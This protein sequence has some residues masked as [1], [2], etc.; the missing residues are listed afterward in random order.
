MK[1][2]VTAEPFHP[3]EYIK[4]ELEARGWTQ[5]D[6]AQV[7]DLSRRQIVNLISGK[8]G[9]S[10]DVARGLAK[11]FD[12]DAETWMRLQIV[13]E[14]SLS[15]Q[16]DAEKQKEIGRRAALY[17]KAPVADMKRRGW[18]PKLKD[19]GDLERAVCDFLGIETI[20][21]TPSIDVAARK[22]TEYTHDTVAQIAWYCRAKQMAEQVSASRYEE[23]N[24]GAMIDALRPL[25]AYP[26][27]VRR[28]PRIL[29]DWGVRLVI[30]E[31]LPKT[32]VDG[33]ALW[34]GQ[35]PAIALS[36]RH[37]QQD[38]FWFTLFHE[39]MH[40]KH[41]HASAVDTDLTE[42]DDS[43]LPETERIVNAEASE[44]MIPKEK[45]DSFIARHKPLFYRTKIIQ[46]AQARGVHPGIVV[47]Q[48]QHRKV[49]PMTHLQRLF[50]QIRPLI[51]GQAR[52]DG[53]D[54]M[55]RVAKQDG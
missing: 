54:K 6:L 4:D 18:I 9:V 45:L 19:V 14:L 29:A 41:K 7:M 52:T 43:G 31:H 21:Q 36:L 49:L 22:S 20:D 13:Y 38:R 47:G 27:E 10:A 46:F 1:H 33:V 35:S 48:L 53:W 44:C 39:C 12:Q 11:A 5:D 28:V 25:M 55:T 17:S 2:F 15:A 16:K 51:V 8:S 24:F 50:V 32:K 34:I 40:I 23:R 26:E 30:V 42:G 37:G 3:G